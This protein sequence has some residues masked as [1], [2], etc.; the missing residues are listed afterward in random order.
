MADLASVIEESVAAPANFKNSKSISPSL[1]IEKG[2]F[3]SLRAQDSKLLYHI[4]KIQK[5]FRKH[6]FQKIYQI[7]QKKLKYRKYVIE[8]IISSEEKYM[9]S[10]KCVINYY[11]LPARQKGLI[12]KNEEDRLFGSIE[13]IALFS[14]KLHS[15]LFAVLNNNFLRN[16]TKI[17]DIFL[18]MMPFFKLYIPYLNNYDL[19]IQLLEK[20]RKT[21]KIATFLKEREFTAESELQDL[22]S[23]LIKPIQ[24]LPKY[25]LLFKDLK[26]NTE[27]SHPDYNN[28]CNALSGIEQMNKEYNSGMREHLKKNKIFELQEKFG[29]STFII[30][31]PQREFVEE[32]A[33]SIIIK[34]FPTNAICY[35][36][37]DMLLIS[38]RVLEAW[39]LLKYIHLDRH[40]SVRDMPDTR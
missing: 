4:N 21:P 35:F 9:N 28:I 25:V 38:E 26:K 34:D 20:L 22:S 24:R 3:E 18:K 31:D 33:V 16:Q 32:E 39:K 19:S 8:E 29:S 14:A 40:S 27:E 13:N 12:S 10:L 15:S 11:I 2:S 5:F 37:T 23:M 30:L 1:S 36:L 7:R 17:A 6:K